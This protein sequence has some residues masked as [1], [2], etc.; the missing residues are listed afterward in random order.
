MK[1][2]ALLLAGAAFGAAVPPVEVKSS[3]APPPS[4]STIYPV[5][6]LR[7]P[8]TAASAGG[9]NTGR[10]F[11]FDDFNIHNLS[12]RGI[13]KDSTADYALFSDSE[14]G[15]SFILRKGKLYDGKGKP[16][17]GVMGK[18]KVREKSAQLETPEHDVQ[19]FRLGDEEKE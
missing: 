15:V 2:I 18:L 6:R 10:P 19:I 14:F 1:T 5:E 7:D 16:V 13:M 17:P 9:T 12:L 8:F 3:T 11:S 4:P